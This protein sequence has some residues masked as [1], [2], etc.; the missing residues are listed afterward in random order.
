MKECGPEACGEMG[1]E[2]GEG[3]LQSWLPAQLLS[4]R[5]S[6]AASINMT[7]RLLPTTS[8]L[9]V[10]CPP[11]LGDELYWV[12]P[13]FCFFTNGL[14]LGSVFELWAVLSKGVV[15]AHPWNKSSRFYIFELIFLVIKG[16]FPW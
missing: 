13:D 9:H 4:L 12:I 3:V 8:Q 16:Y 1:V 10:F 7:G 14:Y 2:G 15:C 6:P 11:V 5:C